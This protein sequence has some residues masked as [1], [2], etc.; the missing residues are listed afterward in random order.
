MTLHNLDIRNLTENVIKNL[1][2][3]SY[4]AIIFEFRENFDYML[5]ELINYYACKY[6]IHV[7]IMTVYPYLYDIE[8]PENCD[9]FQRTHDQPLDEI[10]N[11]IADHFKINLINGKKYLHRI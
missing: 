1:K 4:S 10:F 11:I 9:F 7:V 5:F 6:D 2:Y 8:F 3:N